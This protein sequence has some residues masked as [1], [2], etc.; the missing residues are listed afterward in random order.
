MLRL[1]RETEGNLLD[2]EQ[3]VATLNHSKITSATVQVM[4]ACRLM[5]SSSRLCGALMG[6][7]VSHE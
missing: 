7:L 5:P 3:L 6:F 1:L 2:D 4:Q